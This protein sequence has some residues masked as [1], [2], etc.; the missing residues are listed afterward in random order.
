MLAVGSSGFWQTYFK[1]LRGTPV[2]VIRCFWKVVSISKGEIS[3]WGFILTLFCDSNG[4]EESLRSK[5]YRVVKLKPSPL[6]HFFIILM[7][8]SRPSVKSK[9][10]V[11]VALVALGMRLPGYS[12]V[13]ALLIDPYLCFPMF[14]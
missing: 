8:L 2:S 3:Y 1:K 9:K 13:S 11:Q 5:L 12:K 7:A 14:R 6:V 4:N 10:V